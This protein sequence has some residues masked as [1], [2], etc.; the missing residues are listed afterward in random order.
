[1]KDIKFNCPSCGQSLVVE[2]RAAGMTVP[3][4]GCSN[5][6]VIPQAIPSVGRMSDWIQ[7]FKR[8]LGNGPLLCGLGVY[9]ALVGVVSLGFDA[10]IPGAI[11]AY[12]GSKRISSTAPTVLRY[13]MLGGRYAAL[14]AVC[15]ILLG[16]HYTQWSIFTGRQ[17]TSVAQRVPERPIITEAA[18]KELL[19]QQMNSTADGKFVPQLYFDHFHPIGTATRIDVHD[20]SIEWRNGRPSSDAADILSWTVR[21][22]IRWYAILVSDGYT[23]VSVTYDGEVGRVTRAVVLDSNGQTKEDV[24]HNIGWFLGYMM[25]E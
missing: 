24:A 2:S 21:M 16:R 9:L 18:F 3:C 19:Q 12:L 22:T 20:A 4:P 10:A 17:S 13:L 11:L 1:M 6:I 15:F 23:K 25:A 5:Q 14:L 8:V 7:L